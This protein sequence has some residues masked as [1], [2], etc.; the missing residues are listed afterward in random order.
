MAKASEFL[1]MMA[2]SMACQFLPV[3]KVARQPIAYSYNGVVLPG[4]P[5]TEGFAKAYIYRLGAANAVRHYVCFLNEPYYA[6]NVT[7]EYCIGYRNGDVKFSKYPS[8]TE[9]TN[10]TVYENEGLSS[11]MDNDLVWANFDI[12]NED[13]TVFLEASEPVPVYE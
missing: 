7:G 6:Y 11:E 8:G 4:L 10:K 2:A 9:W 13:G 3:R 12:L 5:E 1:H